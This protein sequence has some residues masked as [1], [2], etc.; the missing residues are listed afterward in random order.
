MFPAKT[1]AGIVKVLHDNLV[2]IANDHAMREQLLQLGFEVQTSTPN[3]LARHL[4]EET[5]RWGKVVKQSGAQ[6]D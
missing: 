2:K 3:E 1:P 6:I 5:A 4:K